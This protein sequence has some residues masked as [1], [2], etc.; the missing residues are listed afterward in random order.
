MT[1]TRQVA[2]LDPGSDPAGRGAAP[3]RPDR[4]IRSA[5]TATDSRRIDVLYSI[6]LKTGVATPIG[7]TGFED[8]E[9]LAFARDCETPLRGRRRDRPPPHLR[10]RDRR[11][12]GGRRPESGHHRHRP[13]RSAASGQLYMSTDAPKNPTSFYRLNPE[14]G[15]AT[16]I[17]DQ[18]QE[19]TGLA[20]TAPPGS[21]GSAATAPTTWCVIDSVDRRGHPDRLRWG[22]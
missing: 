22:R 11:L 17:G 12:H 14:T 6:D 3:R 8:V 1:A 13:R 21:S 20:G 18:G 5:P 15:E 10:H 9:G 19:V 16:L 2:C 7:P 4:P